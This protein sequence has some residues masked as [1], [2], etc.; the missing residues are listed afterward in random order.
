MVAREKSDNQVLP[1][2]L[3]KIINNPLALRS[4]IDVIP[5]KN[6]TILRFGI[7]GFPEVFEWLKAT[8]YIPNSKCSHVA[9]RINQIVL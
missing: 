9:L 8:V 3:N 5:H 7:D 4:T 2:Q 1:L 6:D